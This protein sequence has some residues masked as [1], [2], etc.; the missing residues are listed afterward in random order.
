MLLHPACVHAGEEGKGGV[1]GPP[2]GRRPAA[3]KL[4]AIAVIGC[5]HAGGAQRVMCENVREAR[6]RGLSHQSQLCLG[7]CLMKFPAVTPPEQ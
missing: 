1:N 3:R 6:R 2:A 7:L 4:G 5:A